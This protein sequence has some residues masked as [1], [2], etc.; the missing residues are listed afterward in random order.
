MGTD[1]WGVVMKNTG[2]TE[3]LDAPPPPPPPQKTSNPPPPPPVTTPPPP[4]PATNP[5]PPPPAT[6]PPPPPPPPP[7]PSTSSSRTRSSST[8]R[9]P[10]PTKAPEPNKFQTPSTGGGS[11]FT[12]DGDIQAYLS[13]H[14]SVRAN[15]GAVPLTWSDD[16]ASKAQQWANGCLFQHSGG[17][18][19]RIGEN[20]AAGTGDYTIQTAVK[21][22]TDEVSEYNPSNPKS[23][24][25][26]QVVWKATTQVGCAVQICDGIFDASFGKARYY[27]CE[28]SAAGNVQGQ[29]A[30][31]S[32][33]SYGLL[34]LTTIVATG[35]SCAAL[36]SQAVRTSPGQSWK[37]NIN[38]LII[39]AS[40]S[41]V[42]IVSLLYCGKRRIAVRLKLQRISK[43][44]GALIKNDLPDVRVLFLLHSTQTY[45]FQ[46]VHKYV[47]QEY[48]RACLVSYESLPKDAFH[49]GWGR[50]DDLAR[51]IIPA[52]AETSP[53]PHARM[54]HRFPFILPLLPRDQDGV[55]PLHYYDAAI[56]L[57]RNSGGE[58]SEE[59]FEAGLSAAEDILRA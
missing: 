48:V 21:A 58:L 59:E 54:L 33:V 57:A 9:G 30:T 1:P 17:I 11:S 12:E 23:S 52:Y 7:P 5:P 56:Q 15:H 19:G 31:I 18:F 32:K 44:N 26:T 37:K 8:S 46:S 20:L 55:T 13:S 3:G 53:K 47:A 6:T 40:Y 50:P 28:Y 25:F 36:L 24:H 4:P 45:I 34:V 35:L 49:E 42:L 10:A 14:N 16:L 51:I 39:G 38:A 41:I 22:W 27:V 43:A 2:S 29:F